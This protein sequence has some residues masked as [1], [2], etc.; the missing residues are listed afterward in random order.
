MNRITVLLVE[1]H[2]LVLEGL[3]V[4]L[5]QEEDID[6]V[7]EASDGRQ[8]VQMVKLLRPSV[9]VMDISMPLLNGVEA[10]RQML[11]AVPESNVIFLTSHSDD[12]RFERAM[13]SG[14]VG[15]LLK[16]GAF[17]IL[18][19]A[20]RQVSEGKFF[21]SPQLSRLVRDHDEK[22][23]EWRERCA[24]AHA[25]LSSREMETLQL[26]AEGKANKQIADELGISMKTVEKHRHDLMETL[27]IHDTAGLTRYAIAMGIIESGLVTT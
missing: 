12:S 9:V 5:E 10:A 1:D 25:T 7:G 24:Q 4:L 16:E 23:P 11:A 18:S 6:V 8:A 15:Y 3:R 21:F 22:S 20:I 13:T 26:V 19:K 2:L 14:A 17:Q 27:D